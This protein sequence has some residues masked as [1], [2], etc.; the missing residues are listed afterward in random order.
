MFW[1][2]VEEFLILCK[3]IRHSFLWLAILFVL[4]MKSLTSLGSWRYRPMFSLRNTMVLAFLWRSMLDFTNFCACSKVG[5]EVYFFSHGYLIH[6]VPFANDFLFPVNL[7]GTLVDNHLSI[8]IYICISELCILFLHVI[9]K[10][11]L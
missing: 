1:R 9:P 11:T 6:L 8:Y 10:P 2:V 4:S 3:S 7:H 5:I